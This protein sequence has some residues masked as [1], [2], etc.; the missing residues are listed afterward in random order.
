MKRILSKRPGPRSS[1][2]VKSVMLG[3]GT[4]LLLSSPALA[5]WVAPHTLASQLGLRSINRTFRVNDAGEPLDGPVVPRQIVSVASL[6]GLHAV[7]P[8]LEPGTWVMYD[9]ELGPSW[10]HTPPEEKARPYRSMRW[11]VN[12]ARG[13][14]FVAVLAPGRAYMERGAKRDAD[15]FVAQVQGIRDPVKYRRAVCAVVAEFD[16][17]VYAELS[18][19]GKPSNDADG[20]MRKYRAGRACTRRFALWWLG[21]EEQLTVAQDFLARV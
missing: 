20:L 7:A 4:L 2:L 11:F 17:P 10:T 13:Y 21:E 3:V 9:I 12:A 1:F 16:G 15:A 8:S 18:A 6:A 19:N 14:G 5:A